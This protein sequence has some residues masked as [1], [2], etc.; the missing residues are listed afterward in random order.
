MHDWVLLS[1][2]ILRGHYVDGELR[3]KSE[4]VVRQCIKGKHDDKTNYSV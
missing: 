4:L 1:L 3:I 2:D